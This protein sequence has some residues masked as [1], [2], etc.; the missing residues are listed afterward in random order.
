MRYAEKYQ[1]LSGLLSA[2]KLMWISLYFVSFPFPREYIYPESCLQGI[3]RPG[4]PE[5]YT[6]E[7]KQCPYKELY[8]PDSKFHEGESSEHGI[9]MEG[10]PRVGDGDV[11]W[12]QKIRT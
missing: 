7:T 3:F 11:S 9:K 2:S 8:G 4:R 10:L 1:F 6:C 5:V 12:T